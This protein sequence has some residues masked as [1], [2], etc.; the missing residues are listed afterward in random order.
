MF[1]PHLSLLRSSETTFTKVISETIRASPRHTQWFTFS[2]VDRYGDPS[3]LYIECVKGDYEGN[4]NHH[5]VNVDDTPRDI[6]KKLIKFCPE[7]YCLDYA[8]LLKIKS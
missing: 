6:V 7:L 1:T 2:E 5:Y 4:C 8:N 3:A